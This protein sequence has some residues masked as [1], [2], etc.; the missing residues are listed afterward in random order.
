[1]SDHTSLSKLESFAKSA[2]LK[3]QFSRTESHLQP[4]NLQAQT[5]TSP[6]TNSDAQAPAKMIVAKVLIDL[7][8][9]LQIFYDK[10]DKVGVI[11]DMY[12]VAYATMLKDKVRDFYYQYLARQNF[13]FEVMANKTRSYFHTPE[14]YQAYLME[15]RSTMLKSVIKANT[16]KNMSECLE[17]VIDKL[18]KGGE[19]YSIILVRPASTF[20]GVPSDLRSA[21]GMRMRSHSNILRVFNSMVLDENID[22]PDQYYVDRRYVNNGHPCGRSNN[23]GGY[24]QSNNN[25]NEKQQKKCF[26]C[27]KPRC[28][29]TRHSPEERKKCRNVW[30]S[31]AQD[32]GLDEDL[33]TFL[34]KYEGIDTG[35]Y[36]D[37]NFDDKNLRTWLTN[38]R[39]A[40]VSDDFEQF[41]TA[42]GNIDGYMTTNM[43]NNQ[44]V[45]HALT[46]INLVDAKA[47]EPAHLF[48][49]QSRYDA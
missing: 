35:E 3:S 32:I 21:I 45:I 47:D 8:S 5:S 13:S 34:V 7:D 2:A 20:E 28:W 16:E 30:R 31:Y 4:S 14:K 36:T 39:E 27:G 40:P 26:I 44:S 18:Q 25:R 38:A 23:Q 1:M 11:P 10:C 22:R 37:D 15:W 48:H 42:C 17:M 9:K 12:S 46:N 41:H 24:F 43:L 6:P 49:F 29:S 19:A 33:E